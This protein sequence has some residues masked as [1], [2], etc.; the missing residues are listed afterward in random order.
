MIT[1]YRQGLPNAEWDRHVAHLD[2]GLLQSREW[3]IFQENLG[4]RPLCLEAADWACLAFE[5]RSRGIRYLYAPYGPAIQS[6]ACLEP[7]VTSLAEAGR[8]L[9]V[10]FI[11][12]EPSR[13][14]SADEL[15]RLGARPA[16]EVQPRRTLVLDLSQDEAALKSGVSQSNRNLIN[17]AP[18][19]GI[20]F[21][22]TQQPDP[23]ATD[24]FLA[25]MHETS[26]RDDFNSHTDNYYRQIL[27]TLGPEGVATL[28]MAYVEGQAV[29]GA[30]ALDFAG[31]R[32][33]AH[34]AAFGQL[35]RQYK[36]AV[37]L[38]WEMIAD[39]KRHGFQAFD[40]WGI[41]PSDDPAHPWA[42]LTRFKQSFGGRP[43][44]YAGTWDLP[45]K[46]SK[47]AL[48]RLV[49]KAL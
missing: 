15:T 47:Y 3:G 28:F 16:P 12:F 43:H 13:F 18:K 2:G 10:D 5:R 14:V 7:A 4:Y 33:Y 6:A 42:G 22:I 23:A 49:K 38:L 11:R 39:A 36:A 44:E 48:Y 41:A 26:S 40:F 29:A 1:T 9:G 17:T 20:R 21:L 30:I 25:M 24:A 31:T 8:D 34:A 32:Y 27:Q 45:L 37:P 19:R 35:N 46:S